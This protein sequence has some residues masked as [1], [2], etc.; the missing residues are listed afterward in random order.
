MLVGRGARIK[1]KLFWGVMD[2]KR[3]RTTVVHYASHTTRAAY[4]PATCTYYISLCTSCCNE[5]TRICGG[6]LLR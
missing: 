4:R 3:L 5:I 6:I 2:Q 1:N